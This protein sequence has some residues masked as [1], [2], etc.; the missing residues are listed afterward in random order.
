M[1]AIQLVGWNDGGQ[2]QGNPSH[3]PDPR[4]GTF[5]ELKTAIARI[6]AL[7]VRMILFSKFTWADRGAMDYPTKYRRMA[8]KDPYGDEYVYGGYQ[9]QTMTQFLNINTKRLIPMCFLNEQ[10]MKVCEREFAKLVDLGAAGTLYDESQH[11]SPAL[12]CFDAT[13]GHPYGAPV[14]AK[15][16]ELV[17]RL[18]N[19][20]PKDFLFAGE[21]C[22]DWEF[23]AYHLSYFRTWDPKHVPLLRYLLPHAQILTAITGFNDRNMVNQCLLYRYVMSYECFNF[24]GRLEDFPETLA[25][26]KKMDALRTELREWFW[27]AEFRD[28]VG[29]SAKADGKSHHPFTVFFAKS[30]MAGMAVANY[31]LEK[32]VTVRVSLNNGQKL[33]RYRLVDDDQWRP[34]SEGVLLPPASAAVVVA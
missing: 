4:L 27:D 3:D 23:E 24:K 22:Y 21:A 15:D 11:H 28:T 33:S 31:D 8:I 10:Y 13:H 25:Y 14:Y 32:S 26:G 20:A 1:A 9:Y 6:Q 34:V 2:D 12:Q 29:A 17:W 5:D 30:G 19:H 7:G 18:L 16:R